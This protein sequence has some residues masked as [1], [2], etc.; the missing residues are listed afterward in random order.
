MRE[1]AEQELMALL[2][3]LTSLKIA[4][5]TEV[6]ADDT[7]GE[8]IDYILGVLGEAGSDKVDLEAAKHLAQDINNGLI[9]LDPERVPEPVEE[10]L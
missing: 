6:S 1:I 2:L 9:P 10:I 5:Y 3:N 7:C 8:A 4:T